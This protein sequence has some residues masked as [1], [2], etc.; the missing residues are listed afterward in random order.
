MTSLWTGCA[1]LLGKM[2]AAATTNLSKRIKDQLPSDIVSFIQQAGDTANQLQQRLYLVGGVVRD[3]L[4]ER[5]N[6]DIDMV[7]EGDA[8][9]LAQQIN[10]EGHAQIII[11]PRFGTA[12][13]KWG[14]R[15]A[16]FA[17]ARAETYARPGALPSV[18]PGTIK[19]D[20]ARRDFTINA[21]AV[22]LNPRHFGELID[23][24][25]GQ[26]RF[27]EETGAG[28]PRKKLY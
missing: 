16:D 2:C 3:L 11:H 20:L 27:K 21:M 19:D 6:L 23:P 28:A 9:K 24:F 25:G 4:L 18:K 13:L 22:E 10:S 17:T 7:V 15:S 14:N 12:K 8:I 1:I 5:V 26:G